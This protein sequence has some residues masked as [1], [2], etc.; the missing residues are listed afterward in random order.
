[1]GVIYI[2][3]GFRKAKQ[4]IKGSTSSTDI[5]TS[6]LDNY[7][8]KAQLEEVKNDIDTHEVDQESLI[9]K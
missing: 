3:D 5:D 4:P 2:N 9:I 1:M 8:T 6:I 7:A